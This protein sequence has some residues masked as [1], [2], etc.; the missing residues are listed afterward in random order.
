MTFAVATITK[1]PVLYNLFDRIDETGFILFFGARNFAAE[2][3]RQR[4][5]EQHNQ[6]DADTDPECT[7][8]RPVGVGIRR[9][10]HG[11]RNEV[12]MPHVVRPRQQTA[13]FVVIGISKPSA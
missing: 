9:G 3:C 10:S 1:R 2:K 6:S 5:A 12:V 8:D 7:A 13:A 11:S 4:S